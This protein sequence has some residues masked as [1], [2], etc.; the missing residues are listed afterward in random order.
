VDFFEHQAAARRKSFWLIASLALA[1]LAIA[2]VTQLVATAVLHALEMDTFAAPWIAAG[3]V[4]LIGAGTWYKLSSLA[5]GGGGIARNLGGTRV[6]PDTREPALRRL[7]DAVEQMALAS[8]VPVPEIYVLTHEVGINA[9]TAG[10][11]PS[12]AVLAVTRGGL[13]QLSSDELQGVVAHEFSHILHGDARLNTRLIGLLHGI[14]LIGFAG[15][16]IMRAGSGRGRRREGGALIPFGLALYAFGYPGVFLGRL[17]KAGVSRQ[18]ELAA[19]ASAVQFT[20]DPSGIAGALK[21]IGNF[22]ASSHLSSARA[23]EISH[24]LFSEGSWT[25]TRLL[26]THPPLVERIRALEPGFASE[27]AGSAAAAGGLTPD[28]VTALIGTPGAAHLR[29]AA[30]LLSSL[31]TELRAAAESPREAAAMAVALLLGGDAETR[32]HQLERVRG[33]LGAGAERRARQLNELL[34]GRADMRLAL[35][36]L[37]FPALKQRGAADLARIA[38]L[39][40]ELIHADGRISPFEWALGT[41]LR[42]HIDDSRAAGRLRPAPAARLTDRRPEVA[43]LL[44]TAA[45]LGASAPEAASMAYAAGIATLPRAS[46]PAFAAPESWQQALE[47]SLARLD[48]LAARP[49]RHVIGALVTVLLYDRVMERTEIELL[50]AICA[51]LHCPCPPLLGAEKPES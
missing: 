32:A 31:P 21:K 7:V 3:S 16:F 48:E 22:A 28:G 11:S 9:F 23:D 15:E 8:G 5:S 39:A 44:A 47:T 17:I 43:A 12:D 34:A 49:K 30:L 40:D 19:D 50:R 14:L 33:R 10:M 2:G 1:V 25:L 27:R 4:V 13:E 37:V 18:R 6:T 36:D 45:S 38:V 20:R 46:W 26:A 24:L 41:L 35:V 42:S 51:R 29:A